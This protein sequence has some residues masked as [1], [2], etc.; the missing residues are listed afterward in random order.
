MININEL[1]P[2]ALNSHTCKKI[3]NLSPIFKKHPNR[4]IC[5]LD[6]SGL[7]ISIKCS[8]VKDENSFW[9]NF[10]Q[11][12]FDPQCKV[13]IFVGYFPKEERIWIF[14]PEELNNYAK[15]QH[16]GGVEFQFGITEKNINKFVENEMKPHDIIPFLDR[17][18]IN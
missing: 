10:Q 17:Y 3:S 4:G 14:K 6:Y 11:L 8:R 15:N 9:M 13:Y 5:K 16:P 2:A 18:N 12:Q 7:G 1:S